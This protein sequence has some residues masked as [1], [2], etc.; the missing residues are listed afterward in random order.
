MFCI[1]KVIAIPDDGRIKSETCSVLMYLN[2]LLWITW[3][4]FVFAG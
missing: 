1:T 3:K 4:L 2:I